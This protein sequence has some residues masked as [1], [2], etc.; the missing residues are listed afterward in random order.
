MRPVDEW[1]RLYDRHHADGAKQLL[2]WLM[3]PFIVTSVVGLLWALPVP[4]TFSDATPVLNWGTIFLMAAIVYYFILSISL[5]FGALPLIAL[6]VWA[7]MW[8]ER[9]QYPLWMSC[10]A[11]LVTAWMGQRISHRGP[12]DRPSL[13]GDLQYVML[14]PV[15]LVAALYR[16]LG[17]PF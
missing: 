3:I 7:V 4:T 9:L 11:L 1:L 6:V 17:I 10:T 13:I 12:G 14:G 8:L 15:W 2:H 16:R 5:A